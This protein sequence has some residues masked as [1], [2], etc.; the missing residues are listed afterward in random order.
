MRRK[1]MPKHAVVKPQKCV[2]IIH[3]NPIR[4]V[5]H[6]RREYFLLDQQQRDQDKLQEYKKHVHS[7]PQDYTPADT[8]AESANSRRY[9]WTANTLQ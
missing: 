8:G 3:R 7:P 9:S 1:A 4:Y 6:R 5:V 2:V